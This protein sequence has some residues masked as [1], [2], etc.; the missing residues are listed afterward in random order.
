MKPARA[1][2]IGAFAVAF[3]DGLDAVVFY[4][5]QGASPV[6]IFQAIA[7]GLIGSQAYRGGLRTAAL[8]GLLHILIA[9]V[10]VVVY[11]LASSRVPALARQPFVWGPLYGVAVYIVMNFVVLPLSAGGASSHP[12]PVVINGILIHLFGVGLPAALAARAARRGAALS[13]GPET[14]VR[15]RS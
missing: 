12:V 8:G 3:L 11:F 2:A 14:R 4:G 9:L 15:P 7:S 10:I 13:P 5:L 6:R 1:I